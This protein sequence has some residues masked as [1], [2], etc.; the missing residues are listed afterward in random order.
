MPKNE[1]YG[2]RW[3][4]NRLVRELRLAVEPHCTRFLSTFPE[5]MRGLSDYHYQGFGGSPAT[6]S[7]RNSVERRL[8]A[9]IAGVASHDS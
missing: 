7:P 5:Q 9:G 3:S 6:T 1:S 8:V 2:V 4:P